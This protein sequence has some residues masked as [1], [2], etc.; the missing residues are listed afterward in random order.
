MTSKE[1]STHPIK[2]KEDTRQSREDALETKNRSCYGRLIKE[3]SFK[4]FGGIDL[5]PFICFML[6]R[7]NKGELLYL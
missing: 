1:A 4:C 6:A 5:L 2:W 3:V 7:L